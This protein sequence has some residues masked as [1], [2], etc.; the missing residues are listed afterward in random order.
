RFS[1]VES[2]GEGRH[3]AVIRDLTERRRIECEIRTLEMRFGRQRRDTEAEISRRNQEVLEA[4]RLKSHFLENMNR[5]LRTPLN[6]VIGYSQLLLEEIDGPLNE[7]QR[8]FLDHIQRDSQQLLELINNILDLSRIESGLLELRPETFRARAELRGILEIVRNA[9]SAK[10]IELRLKGGE[11]FVLRADVRRFREILLNL[12]S[13]ALRYTP[14]GGAVI[15]SISTAE[16]A[17]YCCLA[18]QDTGIGIAA[19]HKDAIFDIFYQVEL[20]T[21]GAR[22]VTGLGLAITKHLIEMHGGKIWVDSE[23]GRGSRFSFTMPI[24]S[25]NGRG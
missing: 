1:P 18:V 22:D 25:H 6:T 4:E 3:M 9:A 12:L 7:E 16:E 20:A 17:G 5:G 24:N 21:K 15:V 19:E 2:G 14:G 8:R 11:D 10:S 23:P 13:N